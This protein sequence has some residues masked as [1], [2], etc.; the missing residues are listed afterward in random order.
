MVLLRYARLDKN[1]TQFKLALLTGIHP[2]ALS[3]F[4]TGEVMPNAEHRALIGRALGVNPDDLLREVEPT[5]RE[6]VAS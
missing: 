2:S 3:K 4:E 1:L 6:E 5:L